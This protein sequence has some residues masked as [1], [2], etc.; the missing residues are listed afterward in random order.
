MVTGNTGSYY[1][2]LE[3]LSA[4][5]DRIDWAAEILRDAAREFKERPLRETSKIRVRL[6]RPLYW[7]EREALDD[8][9]ANN[10][11][12]ALVRQSYHEQD[13]DAHLILEAQL[14]SRSL[15]YVVEDILGE[16][17]VN[18]YPTAV[19]TFWEIEVE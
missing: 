12:P 1:F 18:V 17:F 6:S 8:S 15:F 16:E 3:D 2:G 9:L 5:T 4:D 10:F 7:A 14:H 13:R 19:K 11:G